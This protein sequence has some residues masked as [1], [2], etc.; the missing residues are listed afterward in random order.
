[1]YYSYVKFLNTLIL[2]AMAIEPQVGFSP[3]FYKS[4]AMLCWQYY[5]IVYAGLGCFNYKEG[6]DERWPDIASHF[7]ELSIGNKLKIKIGLLKN[8]QKVGILTGNGK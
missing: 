6:K 7:F 4:S 1:M 3:D 2:V 8:F 5:Y